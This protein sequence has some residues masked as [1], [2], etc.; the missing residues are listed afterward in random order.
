MRG[1]EAQKEGT[2]STGVG[3]EGLNGGP[4]APPEVR[5]MAHVESLT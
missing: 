3:G 2:A 5:V 1:P 4:V